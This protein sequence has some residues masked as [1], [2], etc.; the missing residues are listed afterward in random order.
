MEGPLFSVHQ[1]EGKLFVRVKLLLSFVG[2]LCSFVL[3]FVRFV[4]RSVGRSYCLV[5]L[6]LWYVLCVVAAVVA[7]FGHAAP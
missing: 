1:I 7:F 6:L 4:G 2:L 3:S 5:V